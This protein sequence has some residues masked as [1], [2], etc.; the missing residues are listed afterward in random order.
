[1]VYKRIRTLLLTL[2]LGMGLVTLTAPRK[3]MESWQRER[4]RKCG[5]GRQGACR[6]P[7]AAR[8]I[9]TRACAGWKEHRGFLLGG[10][11]AIR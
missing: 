5:N 3:G 9:F 4:N 1:M 7:Q 2:V 11:L 8:E 10:S 6:G